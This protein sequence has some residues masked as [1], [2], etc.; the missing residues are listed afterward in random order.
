MI[1]M[2]PLG[3]L[4]AFRKSRATLPSKRQLTIVTQA[5]LR[6]CGVSISGFTNKEVFN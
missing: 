2:E 4:G 1:R 6:I 5:C 3:L